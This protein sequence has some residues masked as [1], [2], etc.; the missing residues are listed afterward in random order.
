M[1]E[2]PLIPPPPIVRDRLAQHIR[3][4]RL[5]RALYRLSVRAAEER[6]RQ[7]AQIE[8]KAPEG[9]GVGS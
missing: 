2:R 8:T 4:G 9:Q 5:L 3:E 1:D 7:Q 6:H